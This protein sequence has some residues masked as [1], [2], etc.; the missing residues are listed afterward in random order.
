MSVEQELTETLRR[1]G[2]F[3]FYLHKDQEVVH[4]E[5][6]V[7]VGG[8]SSDK[9]KLLS[10][11]ISTMKTFSDRIATAD[12]T[13]VRSFATHCYKCHVFQTPTNY[14]LILMTIPEAPTLSDHLKD[15]H[16]QIVLPLVSSPAYEL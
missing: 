8:Q 6:W 9:R 3:A 12:S 14:K 2:F 10:G 5:N 15:V 4:E 7:D 1:R 16:A 13:T 11:L